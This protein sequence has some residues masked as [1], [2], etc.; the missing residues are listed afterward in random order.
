MHSLCR[1]PSSANG[2]AL[3]KVAKVAKRLVMHRGMLATAAA[4]CA[5]VSSVGTAAASTTTNTAKTNSTK[6]AAVKPQLVHPFTGTGCHTYDYWSGAHVCI[7]IVGSGMV[8]EL[9]AVVT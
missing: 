3:H 2:R 6:A 9:S 4:L 1:S 8:S 7:T 5:L